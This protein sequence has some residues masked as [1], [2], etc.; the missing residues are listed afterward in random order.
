MPELNASTAQQAYLKDTRNW[1][2]TSY[3]AFTVDPV[4]T[5]CDRDEDEQRRLFIMR[6]CRGM[7]ND[8]CD[9]VDPDKVHPAF[10]QNPEIR[11]QANRYTAMMLADLVS[12]PSTSKIERGSTSLYIAARLEGTIP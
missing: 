11:E 1:D 5:L 12:L 10:I 3:E 2:T 6:A 9:N 8:G 7:S 4:L